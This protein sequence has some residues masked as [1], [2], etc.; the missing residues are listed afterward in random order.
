MSVLT[1]VFTA[2]D[3]AKKGY[4]DT[5]FREIIIWLGEDETDYLYI[6]FVRFGISA[7]LDHVT[8]GNEDGK[9]SIKKYMI[10]KC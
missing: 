7:L 3:D 2:G 4:I 6:L 1:R 5:Y 10:L 8:P 9:E